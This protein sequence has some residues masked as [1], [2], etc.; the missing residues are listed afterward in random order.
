[1]DVHQ[2]LREATLAL[3]H[4]NQEAQ[5]KANE[6]LT[7]FQRSPEAWQGAY[8]VF[9]QNE[10]LEVLFLSV[11][12]L[13]RKTRLEWH[14]LGSENLHH[15]LRT[16]FGQMLSGALS[17]IPPPPSPLLRQLCLLQAAALAPPSSPDQ[18]VTLCNQALSM[19]SSTAPP[20]PLVGMELL[21]VIAE[22]AEDLEVRRSGQLVDVLIR[23]TAV[24]LQSLQH[25]LMSLA[26]SSGEC[27]GWRTCAIRA[28]HAW[29]RL[30]KSPAEWG[31]LGPA[32]I[33]AQYPALWSTLTAAAAFPADQTGHQEESQEAATRAVLGALSSRTFG[34]TDNYDEAA[35]GVLVEAILKQVPRIKT[36]SESSALSVAVL[37]AAAAERWPEAICGA[38]PNS[39]I[40][41]NAEPLA[42][43]MLEC[44]RR[45]ESSIAEVSLEYFFVVNTVPIET[46]APSLRGSLFEYMMDA[47]R[48]HVQYPD[49]SEETDFDEDGFRRMRDS[50]APEA[51]EEAFGLVQEGYVQRLLHT[52]TS[53]ETSTWQGAE[54]V[55]YMLGAV[56]LP[57][58]TRVLAVSQKTNGTGRINQL[59]QVLQSLWNF[60]LVH[61]RGILVNSHPRLAA[62]TCWAMERFA[63][64][65]GKDEEAP[66][67][68]AFGAVL[69]CLSIGNGVSGDDES[70][71]A[72][73]AALA[74][75]ALCLRS[76]TRLN[77]M[78]DL[79]QGLQARVSTILNSVDPHP[80]P[81]SKPTATPNP[82]ALDMEHEKLLVKGLFHVTAHLSDAQQSMASCMEL[83]AP[84][85]HQLHS[86]VAAGNNKGNEN[87]GDVSRATHQQRYLICRCLRLTSAALQAMLSASLSNSKASNGS[88]VN[89]DDPASC[90]PVQ[91]LMAVAGPIESLI[92]HS[93]Q[94]TGSGLKDEEVSFAIADV[95]KQ[96]LC[97]ARSTSSAL[98]PTVIPPTLQLFA[99]SVQPACLDVLTEA[100]EVHFQDHSAM[101]D[102]AK[103]IDVAL[104]KVAFPALQGPPPL[105][106]ATELSISVLTLADAM[107]VYVPA[108]LW[109]SPM[110]RNLIELATSAACCREAD[111]V[112]KA[113]AFFG[114]VLNLTM[115][116]VVEDSALHASQ[117]EAVWSALLDMGARITSCL[118]H[119][120]CDTCPRQFLRSAADKLKLLMLH[121]GI[122]EEMRKTWM[123]NAVLQVMQYHD[124]T[125]DSVV[126]SKFLELVF[127]GTVRG[128]RLTSLLMDFGLIARREEG[129]DVLLAHEL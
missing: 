39:Q 64:W 51:L 98:L 78:P 113:F 42:H 88:N 115:E 1:M 21:Q 43:L 129:P 89:G 103:S 118:V 52:L 102:L 53:A 28:A 24:V 25:S 82:T 49:S 104:N 41:R 106:N 5:S 61:Q 68:E 101:E 63:V 126:C 92:R 34:P 44:M 66:L 96:A 46:R 8:D 127:N 45:R 86:I 30:S 36:M 18:A 12:I 23:Q 72:E 111:I 90:I 38:V 71:K 119:C 29:L 93:A 31:P 120:L 99:A 10:P 17:W 112:T 84:L 123:H 87:G 128:P 73:A 62:T 100:L 16:A 3:Y 15:Q 94:N 117:V 7:E 77:T 116:R 40:A 13:L 57:I 109:T 14:K 122:A 22:E 108:M 4:G 48:F 65:F 32:G 83:I 121:P 76:H 9:G 50:I 74:F 11:S 95:Y 70:F 107:A 2:R 56:A 105:V 114:H 54:S 6:W 79:R 125:L 91:M 26:T 27:A 85:A 110:L 67:A 59:K 69:D 37:G 20:I 81:T 35:L 58:K 47:I 80:T 97:S 19:L 124:E 55:I 33:H 75:H 60:L